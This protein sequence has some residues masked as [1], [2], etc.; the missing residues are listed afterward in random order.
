MPY[1]FTHYGLS[2]TSEVFMN[3][4]CLNAQYMNMQINERTTKLNRYIASIVLFHS[5]SYAILTTV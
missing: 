4:Y 3:L 1:C 2:N 5:T